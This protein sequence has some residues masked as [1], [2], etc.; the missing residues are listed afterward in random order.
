VGCGLNALNVIAPDY[1]G[2]GNSS[3][4]IGGYDKRTLAN[5]IH[6][7][8]HEHLKIEQTVIMVGHD[9]GLMVA[10]ATPKTTGTLR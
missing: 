10:Y 4:P 7:L 9:I 1:R 3:R 8:L 5:D 2:A 6:L